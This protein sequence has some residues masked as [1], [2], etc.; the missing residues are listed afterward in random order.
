MYL[1]DYA[2]LQQ[3]QGK[4]ATKSLNRIANEL[5]SIFKK[6]FP[7]KAMQVQP[8]VGENS[9]TFH[10]RKDITS[11]SCGQP[12]ILSYWFHQKIGVILQNAKNLL[13]EDIC[14][15]PEMYVNASFA[16]LDHNE[17]RIIH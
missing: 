9:I 10:I 8:Q 3:V 11:S 14:D 6:M 16:F 15:F 1:T 2:G 7:I 4:D 13:G 12:H 5:A 17:T